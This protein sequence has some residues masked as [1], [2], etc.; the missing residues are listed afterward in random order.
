[1]RSR[2]RSR[3]SPPTATRPRSRRLPGRG[4]RCPW[5][6]AR[7][8]N[9]PRLE[10]ARAGSRFV[11]RPCGAKRTMGQLTQSDRRALD[12]L[13]TLFHREWDPIGGGVAEDAYDGYALHTLDRLI[14]GACVEE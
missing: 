7:I 5:R 11:P 3:A 2:T 1:M 9:W 6:L 10:R 4:C 8:L 13:R 14:H 12:A